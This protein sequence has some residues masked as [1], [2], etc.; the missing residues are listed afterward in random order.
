MRNGLAA[1]LV[2]AL[3]VGGCSAAPD[4]DADRRETTDGESVPAAST[5]TPPMS[6]VLGPGADAATTQL[7]TWRSVKAWG[8][9]RVV[10]QP[11]GGGTQVRATAR[12]KAAT[13]VR[14]S[15]SARPAYSAV[16]TGLEPGTRYRYRVV[17]D[18]GSAGDYHFTTAR[19]GVAPWTFLTLGDTQVQNA[20]RPAAIVRAA[21]KRFPSANLVLHAGDVVNHPWEHQEWV[22]LMAALAP[23]RTSRNVAVSIGNHEQ[24]ILVRDCRSGGAQG[25]RTYFSA[26]SNGYAGQRST[27]Y[28]FDQQGVRFVVLDAFGPDLATQARFLDAQLRDNPNRWS[29]VLLHAGPFASRADRTNQA[30]FDRILPILQKRD[31]DLVLSGHDHVY[32]SGYRGDP[33]GPVFATSVAGPKYY[34]ISRADWDRRGATRTR[35]AERTSTYQVVDVTQDTLRYRSIVA[36]KGSGARPSTSYGQALDDV[37][38]RKDADGGKTVTRR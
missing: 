23:V 38:I 22:D 34:D 15:G 13:T 36:S 10:A 30:V 27:W 2:A 28:R 35:W 19:E 3:L 7:V 4:T 16:L 8:N 26:P 18:G 37:L 29:V 1:G 32:S 12:R 25:F 9:Q 14:D 24:C 21:V 5:G 33:D 11:V 17:N 31:V 20:D 6:V